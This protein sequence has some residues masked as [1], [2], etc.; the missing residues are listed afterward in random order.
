MPTPFMCHECDKFTMNKTGIC[1]NCT[2]STTADEYNEEYYEY[3][4]NGRDKR[5]ISFKHQKSFRNA[6]KDGSMVKS[7]KRKVKFDR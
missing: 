3:K 2:E 7:H 4:E 6:R 1:D 5:R